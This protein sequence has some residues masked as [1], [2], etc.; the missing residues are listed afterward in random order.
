VY[1]CPASPRAL[2]SSPTRRSSDLLLEI[3]TEQRLHERLH[4]FRRHAAR[5]RAIDQPVRAQRV[6]THRDLLEG[7]LDTVRP[8]GRPHAPWT[9][10]EEHTSA[11]QSRE[12]LLCRLLLE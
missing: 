11:L 2:H 9:R 10:S 12:K 8:R 7:E 5:L 4:T 3:G 1:P 6:H